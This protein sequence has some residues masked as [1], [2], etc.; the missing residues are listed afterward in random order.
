MLF[1]LYWF[2]LGSLILY[3]Y[4]NWDFVN[5]LG[6]DKWLHGLS[7]FWLA[8]LFLYFSRQRDG[9]FLFF[10]YRRQRDGQ[11]FARLQHCFVAM[12][13]VLIVGYAWEAHEG[14]VDDF[15]NDLG[16][17]ILG[18]AVCSASYLI[19]GLLIKYPVR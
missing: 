18:A 6:L 19:L 12:V 8:S 16:A 7:G 11:F 10:L 14:F 4:H 2:L 1:W 3:G 5:N 13:L 17:D 15:F 9:Q